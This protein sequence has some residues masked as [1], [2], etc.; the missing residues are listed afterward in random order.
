MFWNIL[1]MES[2]KVL[3][4][5]L[6]W[7]GLPIAILPMCIAFIAFFHVDQ[8]ASF[9]RYWLWPGGLTSAL[10]FANGYSPG[11]GYAAYL[12]AVVVGVVTAQ[13]YSWRTMQLWLSHGISRS[14]L[15]LAKYI[16]AVGITLLITLAFLLVGGLISVLLGAQVHDTTSNNTLDMGQ[17]FLSYLLTFLLVVVSRSAVV[18]ISGLILFMLAIELPLT[19]LLPALGKG[20]AQIVQFLPVGLAQAMNQENYTA[21]HLAM[22]TLISAGHP[23][24][25]VAALCIAVYTSALFGLSLWIFQHQNFTN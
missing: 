23:N 25:I 24:T 15:F 9:S 22:P 17:L 14:Y 5:R 13:E 7:I 10:A 1:R 3:K 2:S 19:A 11:Y 6:F 8:S 18:A 16:L 12:L 4:R 21:A 20:P